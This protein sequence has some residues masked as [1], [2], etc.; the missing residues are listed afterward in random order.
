MNPFDFANPLGWWAALLAVPVVALYILK[1]RMRQEQVSTLLFWDQVFDEKRPRA[2]WQQLRR[3]LSLLLQI[4]FLFLL[5]SALTDPL[6]SWQKRQQRS[7]ALVIDN[8]A[9]MQAFE[10]GAESRIDRAKQTGRS[11]IRSLRGNDRMTLITAGGSPRVV[12]GF[13]DHQKS[14]LEALD[15]IPITDGPT[16]VATAIDIAQRLLGDGV[17]MA[18]VVVLTDGAFEM[19]EGI[20][21]LE[22][23]SLYGVG[24]EL[25]NV[26]I[27]RYQVRRSLQDAIGYQVL[28]DVTNF[29]D[30][31]ESR[32]LSVSLG[33]DLVDVVPLTLAPGETA[34]RVLDHT[35]ADGGILKAELDEDALASD[36]SAIAFLPKRDPI[37]VLL[38]TEG[39]LFLERVLDSIPLVALQVVREAP[40]SLSTGSVLVLDR[41]TTETLPSG[42]V[43]VI[44]PRS[45]SGLW[46]LGESIAEPIVASVDANSPLTQHVRLTNVLFPEA[47][48]L[49][50]TTDVEPL[51]QDPLDQPLM[52]RIKRPQG[53]I[54]VLTCSLEKGDL[55]LRIAFPV[56]MKNSIEWFQG[57]DDDLQHATTSGNM[58]PV[59]LQLIWDDH[60]VDESQNESIDNAETT[61]SDDLTV[62][63][64]ASTQTRSFTLVSPAGA[65]TPV[66][67]SDPDSLIGPLSETGIW[68]VQRLS[69]APSDLNKDQEDIP[70]IPI[71]CNLTSLD[72][73]DLRPRTE[74]K[75]VDQLL[76]VSFGG[77][78][79]WFYLTLLAIVLIAVE[80][81]LYQRRIVE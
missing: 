74:V 32:Q 5:V 27:T 17:G 47:R 38:V 31:E 66:M 68:Q 48:Q 55:P 30:T 37:P 49:D 78:S 35:S 3:L 75:E 58:A 12:M 41:Q 73:S 80:W 21:P 81:L 36:N 71:A 57:I 61:D 50:F 26:G 53:D 15:A 24:S 1:T 72:E 29:S 62:V 63:E 7:I 76:L 59:N 69:P 64:V 54:L 14:L 46:K 52:A 40:T 67:T 19:P 39:N 42:H 8:S 6:W 13:T 60:T 28:V 9:S 4:I 70:S 23:V 34:T 45:S 56:L 11:L 51:I 77:Y 18:E 43:M 16:E 65:E 44:D 25:P 33:D 2:W 79:L 20:S 22:S 10:D